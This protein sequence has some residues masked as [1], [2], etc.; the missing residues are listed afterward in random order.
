MIS[1]VIPTLNAERHIR[2][3]M[4]SLL[5]QTIPCEI[6]VV[7]SSSSDRTVE[8]A[9]SYG[10]KTVTID[11]IAFDHGGTRNL[12]VKAAKGD[13]IIFLTQDAVPANEHLIEN[14]VKPLH[15]QRI[16][17]SYGRQIAK[18]NVTP[19]ERFARQFNYPRESLIKG[20]E[21]I[22]SLGIKTFFCSNVCSAVRKR[23]FEEMGGFP[24]KIIINEDM[25]FAAR[26]V[27]KG[28]RVAYEPSAVLYHSHNYSLR[29]QFKRYFDI[30]VF[31]NRNRWIL[32][33][34][35]PSGEGIRF[36]REGLKYLLRKRQ[37]WWIP[38]GLLE[39]LFRYC[40][41]QLGLKED[42]I[43]VRLKMLIS[44]HRHFWKNCD[45]LF[46]REKEKHETKE[47]AGN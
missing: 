37:W 35:R 25:L 33:L 1:V 16:A 20:K 6:I 15:D 32:T 22:E 44:M 29:E 9:A 18:N 23:Q 43:P 42:K 13:T 3:L 7:D 30:G 21:Q 47:I 27:M 5:S 14:L 40:G 2:Q 28:Y 11:R 8:V 10:A 4:K 38:Y 39:A 36:V 17:L 19:I 26:L 45:T 41:Y 31:F 34:G 46:Q 24:E 12:A